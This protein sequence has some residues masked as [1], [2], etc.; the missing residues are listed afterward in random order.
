VNKPPVGV[1]IVNFNLKD[2]L[3]E[4][5]LSFQKVHYPELQIVVSDNA[6]SDGSQEMVTK[7]FPGVQLLAHEQEQGYARAASLGMAQ[8]ADKTKYIFST[9]ND[10]VVDPEIINILVD[11]AETHP[12]A[13]VLGTKIYFFDRPDVL[14]HAGGRIHPL[15]GHSYHLGWERKDHP[16]YG[17]TREC[18]FV[19]GC[20]F[21]LRTDVLRK[22]GFFKEDLIFYSE[23]AELCY[24]FREAG[25]KVVFIPEAKMWHKVSTTLA[26]NRPL[27]L[28]Y[29]TRNSLY[30][31]QR[32]KVGWYPLSLL[33][34][35]F[36]V[37]PVK[38]LLFAVLLKA[39]N[40]AGIFRGVL[41]WRAGRYGWLPPN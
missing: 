29:S 41:D 31:L 25:S 4:T 1:V 21:L 33:V 22:I 7:E 12:E 27:Q 13:G 2:S 9:T 26:K 34:F 39:K 6:S 38:M 23:D 40:S 20:G 32:H 8:L 14:W 18:D 17:K 3:R 15:H 24:R 16:R 5:L 19:T 36:V 37:S 11:Y 35:L 30:L 28:C 10:V